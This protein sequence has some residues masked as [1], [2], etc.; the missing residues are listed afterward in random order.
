LNF[1]GITYEQI[2][3]RKLPA[4]YIPTSESENDL[5]AV[6]TMDYIDLLEDPDNVPKYT[7]VF[8]YNDF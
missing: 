4:P 7:G 1:L 2:Q 6:D 3:K 8:D 5:T